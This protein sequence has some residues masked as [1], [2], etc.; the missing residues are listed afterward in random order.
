[1]NAA[2]RLKRVGVGDVLLLTERL[3]GG[4]S[5]NAGSDKQTY[6]RLNPTVHEDSVR[7]MAAD[8]F[9][10]GCMHGDIAFVEAALST[11]AF[12][13]LVELGV[14]FPHDRYGAYA[15]YQTDN[16][17]A[18]RG[19]S[20]GPKT[21]ISMVESLIHEAEN[22]GV[23]IHD[24]LE[25]ID[26]LTDG[27]GEEK[28]AVGL[29]ALEGGSKPVVIR[30]DY[31]VYGTGGPGALFADSVYPA[32]QTGSLGVALRA[33]VKA[34][35]LTE[36]QFGIASTDFRWNL[37]GSYQQVLPRYI[38]T[39]TSGGDSKDFL[40]D[41]FPTQECQL[42]AQF[43]K[44]YQWPFDVGKLADYGS[45]LIDLAVYIESRLKGRAVYIDFRSNPKYG[46]ASFAFEELPE[47]AR[48]YLTQS[49][50]AGETPLE[51]LKQMNMPAYELYKD[52]GVDLDRSLV[53]VAVCHQH[54]NGG[55]AGSIWWESNL[56]NFFPVGECCGT[57][58]VYRPG[59]SALNSGQVGSIRAAEMI[60]YRIGSRRAK[61]D[62]SFSDKTLDSIE[63]RLDCLDGL[64]QKPECLDIE[65]ERKMIQT[66]MAEALGILRNPE[67]IEKAI[68]SNQQMSERRR[69]FG[70][71]YR[72][73]LTAY[74]KNEDLLMTERA[75]LMSAQ[76][77]IKVL[78]GGRGSYLIGDPGRIA[79]VLRQPGQK[80]HFNERLPDSSE[81]HRIVQYWIDDQ[82]RDHVGFE[83]VRPLPDD[84]IWFE[85]VWKEYREGSY[86]L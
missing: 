46:D 78:E 15:G 33:G 11:R 62:A 85:Q 19:T 34:Q 70:I 8:L 22:V 68:K 23:S 25:V 83:P 57:H 52:N 3:G 14:S 5:A 30:S 64:T 2:V 65:T 13:H 43:L 16:D 20:A 18:G 41:Y 44:G 26:L 74:L 47:I 72:A 29:L 48:A 21:S 55:L 58:G 82:N 12:Y 73:Q 4:T 28:R 75:F 27:H 79:E 50:A 56:K 84:P 59:G 80:S 17:Q 61:Q 45:S 39:D 53:K 37:S 77:L 54:C 63:K 86:Y 1:M 60:R 71:E 36:S 42:K 51:R 31:V 38:S 66:R 81:D 10:G 32:S 24:R 40:N 49:G 35:N 67:Q 6:Y 9:S 69:S 76:A 7:G